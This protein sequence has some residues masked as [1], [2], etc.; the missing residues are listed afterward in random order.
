MKKHLLTFYHSVSGVTDWWVSPTVLDWGWNFPPINTVHWWLV[1]IMSWACQTTD[2]KKPSTT[3]YAP[4]L[5]PSIIVEDDLRHQKKVKRRF[6]GFRSKLSLSKKVWG[7]FYAILTPDRQHLEL[8]CF[9]HILQCINV[10]F[11][12]HKV[13][14][15]QKNQI[16]FA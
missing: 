4:T 12:L 14:Y 5:I 8:S 10:V 6:Y 16:N 11:Y 2:L 15:T 13:A 3:H 9:K 7:L 1:N